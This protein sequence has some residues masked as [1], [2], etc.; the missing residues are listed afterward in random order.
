M[1]FVVIFYAINI[2]TGKA[3]NELPAFTVA[4]FI[5]LVAFII[6]LPI[7]F[8]GARQFRTTFL[9]YKKPFLV[10]TL[11]GVT[12]FNTFI[13]GSLQFTTASNVSV[14]EAVIPVVTVILSVWLLKERLQRL[15]WTGV[16]LSFIGALWVVM[17]GRVFQLASIDWNIGD[18]IM[19]GAIGSWAVYS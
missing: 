18:A 3:L 6:L 14:L 16:L 10:M 1:I 2:L 4:F 13:Y 7:G 9:D 11:T 5:L 8:R 15:Q 19:I 17:D 12:F